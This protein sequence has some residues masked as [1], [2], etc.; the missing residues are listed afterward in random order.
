MAQVVITNSP[1][2]FHCPKKA[3][4]T[5]NNQETGEIIYV[6]KSCMEELYHKVN[7]DV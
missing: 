1:K 3:F 5:L 2:C 4:Y 6:C 7:E